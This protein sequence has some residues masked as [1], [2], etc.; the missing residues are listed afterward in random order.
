MAQLRYRNGLHTPL[1]Y[2]L[3]DR[4]EKEVMMTPEEK[5]SFDLD[6]YLVV[7]NVLTRAEVD[8]LNA[9]ADEA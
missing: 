4:D 1:F 8:A 3:L 9:L 6:G 2:R 7:K 5:F